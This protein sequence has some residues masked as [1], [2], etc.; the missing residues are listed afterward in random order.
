MK[1]PKFKAYWASEDDINTSEQKAF[2][3]HFKEAFERGEAV[4]L[5][6]QIS[7][8]IAFLRHERENGRFTE[9]LNKSVRIYH[10]EKG[11]MAYAVP[12]LV[13]AYAFIGNWEIV[14]ALV[15]V[16][17]KFIPPSLLLDEDLRNG[18]EVTP[19]T[20]SL[21]RGPTDTPSTP[22]SLQSAW[23]A[24][25]ALA[26]SKRSNL[27]EELL[28]FRLHVLKGGLLREGRSFTPVTLEGGAG[29]SFAY[30]PMIEPIHEEARL[31][32]Q[33]QKLSP[34]W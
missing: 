32:I 29:D 24:H 15:R 18:K 31:T 10:G 19:K 26:M 12:D 14:S 20:I 28:D 7:Y 17:R 8:L 9:T 22:G 6:G 34:R 1:P 4:Q 21:F 25:I 27:Q 16:Y 23:E 5:G 13:L 33:K 30:R 3:N 11:F 2:Y